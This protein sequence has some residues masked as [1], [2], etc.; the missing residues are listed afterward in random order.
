MYSY[1]LRAPASSQARIPATAYTTS[2][3]YPSI[4]SIVGGASSA[5]FSQ[6]PSP[7]SIV[8]AAASAASIAASV[9]A[10]IVA[11]AA[12]SAASI[13]KTSATC[14]ACIAFAVYTYLRQIYFFNRNS[15]IAEAKA[16]Q[17][18]LNEYVTSRR[19]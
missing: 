3:A 4:S 14:I 7:S 16:I 15:M 5:I 19:A 9:A 6:I 2:T 18:L 12:F 11:A 13:I 8:S 1:R 17:R 10:P